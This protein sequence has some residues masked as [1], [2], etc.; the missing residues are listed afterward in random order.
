MIDYRVLTEIKISLEDFM[1][2]AIEFNINQF[3]ENPTLD[4]YDGFNP[5]MEG[6][7][8]FGNLLFSSNRK[9]KIYKE[10]IIDHHSKIAKFYAI[11]NTG[12]SHGFIFGPLNKM[13]DKCSFSQGTGMFYGFFEEDCTFVYDC[14]VNMEATDSND[15]KPVDL[16]LLQK[17]YLPLKREFNRYFYSKVKCDLNKFGPIIYQNE[18]R[19]FYLPLIELVRKRL[20]LENWGVCIY[21][22]ILEE[23]ISFNVTYS[24][25]N[26]K[27]FHWKTW[28]GK[29][30]YDTFEII[31]I[32]LL[33]EESEY[34]WY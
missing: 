25:R 13:I 12:L 33:E 3:A 28:A 19:S 11:D 22:E 21:P 16:D 23:Y 30:S 20:N 8:K 24:W 34:D 29:I 7:A 15:S 9:L 27:Y 18:T 17:K 31:E 1:K 32:S 26:R 2:K 5:H 6:L 4:D 14:V 10:F